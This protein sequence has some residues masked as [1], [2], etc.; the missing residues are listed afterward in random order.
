MQHAFQQN[1]HRYIFSNS[2]LKKGHS[3]KK[4]GDKRTF[5]LPNK[6]S[7]LRKIQQNFTLAY[8]S[9]GS[10]RNSKG[11][12]FSY[13]R[14][15]FKRVMIVQLSMHRNIDDERAKVKATQQDDW[16]LGVSSGA[17]LGLVGVRCVFPFGIFLLVG[18]LPASGC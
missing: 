1:L 15:S 11:Y 2:S 5:Y 10:V 12:L 7:R 14:I 6:I 18:F 3:I 17:F 9:T 13:I 4:T 8:F 16:F